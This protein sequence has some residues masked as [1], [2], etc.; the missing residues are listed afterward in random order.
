MVNV[1]ADLSPNCKRSFVLRRLPQGSLPRQCTAAIKSIAVRHDALDGGRCGACFAQQLATKRGGEQTALH[2]DIIPV[3]P[4][5]VGAGLPATVVAPVQSKIAG[6]SC[7]AN[8]ARARALQPMQSAY[9]VHATLA[10]RRRRIMRQSLHQTPC[11]AFSGGDRKMHIQTATDMTSSSLQDLQWKTG[12]DRHC[13][14]KRRTRRLCLGRAR[15]LA[16]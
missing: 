8:L 6:S 10:F 2:R 13:P 7:L 16:G 4:E 11:L 1:H 5:T 14:G 15:P 12:N 9:G 3:L